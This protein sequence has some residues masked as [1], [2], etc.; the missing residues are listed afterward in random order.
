MTSHVHEFES[1]IGETFR[2]SL[3]YDE[4]TA[5][6]AHRRVSRWLVGLAPSE[7][8][9]Q[10]VEFETDDPSMRGEMTNTPA[11]SSSQKLNNVNAPSAIRPT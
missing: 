4:P 9:V 5:L 8:V 3:T 1:S 11:G 10:V 2:I 7:P 6:G